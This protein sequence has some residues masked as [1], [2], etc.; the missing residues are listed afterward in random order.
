M[1][2]PLDDS[3]E[4]F[5]IIY[6]RN[7]NMLFRVS[8]SYMKSAAEAEDIVADVFVKLLKLDLSFQNAEHQKA[9]LLRTTINL[10]KDRLKHW[11]RKWAEMPGISSIRIRMKNSG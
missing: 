7:V 1:E 10:C 11:W 3:R 9:W 6:E 2:L 5:E 8:F 4:S